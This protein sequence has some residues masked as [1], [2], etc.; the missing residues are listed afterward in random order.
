DTAKRIVDPIGRMTVLFC[1][2][3][4]KRLGLEI[5][6]EDFSHMRY[7]YSPKTASKLIEASKE[8]PFKAVEECFAF[9]TVDDCVEKIEDYVKAGTRHFNIVPLSSDFDQTLNTIAENIIPYFKE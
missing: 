9:G 2:D 3:R 5:P 6:T 7:S 1:P 8:V 4:L